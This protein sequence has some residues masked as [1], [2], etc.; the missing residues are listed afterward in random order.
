ML[1]FPLPPV[2]ANARGYLLL[3]TDS[4][5]ARLLFEDGEE[6]LFPGEVA[7]SE[8]SP[9][10]GR[11][12]HLF[13]LPVPSTD[14]GMTS[15]APG[16]CA[17]LGEEPSIPNRFGGVWAVLPSE[18]GR[19]LW[20]HQA[21][22]GYGEEWCVSSSRPPKGWKK[23]RKAEIA[24]FSLE[25][26]EEVSLSFILGNEVL[27]LRKNE[28][29]YV[30]VP[31]VGNRL[32]KA[33]AKTFGPFYGKRPILLNVGVFGAQEDLFLFYLSRGGGY[34]LG[35]RLSD[36]FSKEYALARLQREAERLYLALLPNSY[37][38][39]AQGVGSPL[40]EVV[41]ASE[42]YPISLTEEVAYEARVGIE[43]SLEH[44]R[45]V[46]EAEVNSLGQ[47]LS[48]SA[49]VE[50][51]QVHLG[52]MVAHEN[53]FSEEEGLSASLLPTDWVASFGTILVHRAK[54]EPDLLF[55]ARASFPRSLSYGKEIRVVKTVGRDSLYLEAR[56]SKPE[57]LSVADL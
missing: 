20:L 21:V 36:G 38:L 29:I 12:R 51:L 13:V 54:G 6:V 35:R 50:D 55:S 31:Q 47:P 17:S 7:Y 34:V 14:V 44:S 16:P 18:D 33:E 2:L 3:N 10:A 24:N 57:Y 26:V 8:V 25:K 56:L 30:L 15:I 49:R 9:K 42:M 27:A 48:A 43:G 39:L 46:R 4:L 19:E 41:Y 1:V 23:V 53:D 37:L 11:G 45:L 32:A 22:D 5:P 28:E 52:R 40:P